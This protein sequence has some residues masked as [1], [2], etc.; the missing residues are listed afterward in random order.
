MKRF[1]QILRSLALTILYM[2]AATVVGGCFRNWGIQENIVVVYLLAVLLTSRST[3]GYSYGILASLLAFLL[4]NW[5]FTEPY[6]SLKINDPSNIITVIIMSITA[7][8]TSALTLEVRALVMMAVMDIMI[9]VMILE[10]S[11]IFRL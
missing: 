1:S 2:A 4:Y 5:Y 7:I 8:I 3:R 10:G 9:T 6:H 11:L